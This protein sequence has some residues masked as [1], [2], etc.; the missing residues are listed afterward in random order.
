M[1]LLECP[2]C[3]PRDEHEFNSGGE[4]HLVRPDESADDETWGQ[5]LYFRDNPKGVHHERWCHSFGCGIWFNVARDT[6]THKI[7]RVYAITEPRP[8]SKQ[9]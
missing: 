1:F 4:G 9:P 6:A 3:G 2:Y 5:Y 7:L 8:Q